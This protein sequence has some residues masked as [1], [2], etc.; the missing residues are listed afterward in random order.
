MDGESFLNPMSLAKLACKGNVMR[1]VLLTT[2][3]FG[4]FLGLRWSPGDFTGSPSRLLTKLETGSIRAGGFYYCAQPMPAGSACDGC[5][6]N[7]SSFETEPSDIPGMPDITY[8]NSVTCAAVMYTFCRQTSF[9]APPNPT[10]DFATT[11]CPGFKLY[12][13]GPGCTGPAAFSPPV[14]LCSGT[15][16]Y[17]AAAPG[18]AAVGVNCNGIPTRSYNY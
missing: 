12:F 7:T 1:I 4:V 16:N 5:D 10:C 18:P 9:A 2:I 13:K 3:V 15:R 8:E 11:G 14:F 6:N 17:G